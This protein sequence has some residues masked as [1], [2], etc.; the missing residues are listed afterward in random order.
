MFSTQNSLFSLLNSML[1]L[2]LGNIKS[3][4]IP[5]INQVSIFN[6]LILIFIPQHFVFRYILDYLR[7]ERLLLPDNFQ[8]LL[9]NIYVRNHLKSFELKPSFLGFEFWNNWFA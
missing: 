2:S 9:D 1:Q 3:T 4:L 7:N 6:Q 8:V 5:N